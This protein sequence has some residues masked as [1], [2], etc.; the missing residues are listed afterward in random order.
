MQAGGADGV[1]EK[2]LARAAA[3]VADVDSVASAA[4]G[5][6]GEGLADDD[7]FQIVSR[8]VLKGDDVKIAADVQSMID[9]GYAA[10]EIMDCG[11]LPAMEFIGARF[12]DGTVFIPEV[13]LSARAMNAAVAVLEP[14]LVS[15][16]KAP[17][18]K[19]MIGTV[20][21]DL[22]DIGKNMVLTMMRSVG[23]ETIDLGMD[24]P[25]ETFVAQVK[26]HRPAILALSA[27][28]T[29]TMPQMKRVIDALTEA[30]IRNEVKV[31]I[32]GA[33]VNQRYA[34]NI[35]A[36]GYAQDAGE[37]VVLTKNILNRHG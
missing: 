9:Q 17:P 1:S 6:V 13:L 20:K 27:L 5:P 19:I 22:H 16:D 25:V 32:G 23:F 14:Y 8:D 26:A 30:G 36:D 7:L 12:T 18:A 35:G 33:P 10:Q 2:R 15:D 34:K 31:I 11:L 3:R 29:T 4:V 28:L 21:G 24:V 37:A